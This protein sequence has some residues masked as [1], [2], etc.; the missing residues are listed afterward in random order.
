MKRLLLLFSLCMSL[1]VHAQ[2]I[3]GASSKSNN[4]G[5]QMASLKV[6]KHRTNQM[7]IMVKMGTVS[8]SLDGWDCTSNPFGQVY[9]MFGGPMKPKNPECR[10]FFETGLGFDYYSG[11]ASH[12]GDRYGS[13]EDILMMGL[14]TIP[15]KAKYVINPL[16]T[17]GKWN[18][19]AGIDFCPLLIGVPTDETS[20]KS[21]YH[22]LGSDIGA[23]FNVEGGLGYETNHWGVSIGAFA[24]VTVIYSSDPQKGSGPTM[25]GLFG[26]VQYKW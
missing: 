9:F 12:K 10:W 19:N 7:G 1:T 26:S 14:L 13:D 21:S 5:N 16:S 23:K 17:R 20:G 25:T 24:G 6:K 15:A 8:Y 2:S 4:A 11:K 3:I 22:H 18:L